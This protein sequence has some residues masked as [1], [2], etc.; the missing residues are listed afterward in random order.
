MH[1]C[2]RA[3]C[4][5]AMV[6]IC[7]MGPAANAEIIGILEDNFTTSDQTLNNYYNTQSGFTS[8]LFSG[9][10]T[11]ASL[12][13]LDLLVIMHP[14]DDFSAAE[15]SNIHAYV[16]AGGKLALLGELGVSSFVA[17][18]NRINALLAGL[19]S[20]IALLNNQLDGGG[21]SASLADGQISA[22]LLTQ[23][24]T[25]DFLYAGVST[26][27]GEPPAGRILE[28]E[29]LPGGYFGAVELIGAGSLVAIGD[30]SWLGFLTNTSASNGQLALNMAS[31]DLNP[32]VPVPSTL[33]LFPWLGAIAYAHRRRKAGIA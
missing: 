17:R 24:M 10:V 23:G 29:D 9:A 21:R 30:T 27:S 26:L 22:H 13:G 20:S 8:T 1:K 3:I 14:E 32:S 6:A 15:I 28:S 25:Q 16:S 12:A 18:N 11:S 4:A 33:L 2:L 5:T 19:G 31:L 7:G